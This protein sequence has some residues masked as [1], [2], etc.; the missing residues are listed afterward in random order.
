MCKAYVMGLES[1]GTRW[2]GQLLQMTIGPSNVHHLSLPRYEHGDGRYIHDPDKFGLRERAKIAIVVRDVSCAM[3][4]NIKYNRSE[5]ECVATASEVADI[6]QT[7]LA[8]SRFDTKVF[9]YESAMY[10]RDAYTLPW[11]VDFTGVPFPS[12][13]YKVQYKDG[14]KKYVQGLTSS[15]DEL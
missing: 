6:L 14:N 10:L 3:A 5:E 7:Y 4:S 15:D 2:L 1:S 12:W 9:S 8:D 11:I 13:A